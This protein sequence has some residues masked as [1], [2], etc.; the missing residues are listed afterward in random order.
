MP[1]AH[2]ESQNA[3]PVDSHISASLVCLNAK[4]IFANSLHSNLLLSSFVI[5]Q[6]HNLD[7]N[8]QQK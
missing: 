7:K 8:S 6:R 2:T 4:V 1:S 3:T 5:Y